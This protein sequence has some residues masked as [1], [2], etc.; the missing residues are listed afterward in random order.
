[1]K[2]CVFV[3]TYLDAAAGLRAEGFSEPVV[4]VSSNVTDY[5][6]EGRRILVADLAAEFVQLKLEYAPNLPAAKHFLWQ[7][8]HA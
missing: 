2:D 4:F 6:G 8:P 5:T 1:M 3:E 7:R